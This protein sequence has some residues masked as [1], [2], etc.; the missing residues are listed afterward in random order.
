MSYNKVRTKS[1]CNKA[2]WQLK[3]FLIIHNKELQGSQKGVWTVHHSIQELEG[4]AATTLINSFTI[5][6]TMLDIYKRKTE[7]CAYTLGNTVA[8][9]LP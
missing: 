2:G 4:G 3:A 9:G 5:I 8:P 6:F 7:F 1:N